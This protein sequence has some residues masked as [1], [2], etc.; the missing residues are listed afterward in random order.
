[1]FYLLFFGLVNCSVFLLLYFSVNCG[2]K[3]SVFLL[4]F[5][6]FNKFLLV[7]L[8]QWTVCKP[9]FCSIRNKHEKNTFFFYHSVKKAAKTTLFFQ[10]LE[11][12]KSVKKTLLNLIF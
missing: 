1:M 5:L 8:A 4:L 6:I 2:E 7:P 3:N 10:I 11:R 9:F 12:E